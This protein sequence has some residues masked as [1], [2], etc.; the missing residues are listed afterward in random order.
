MRLVHFSS[1]SGNTQRFIDYVGE[2][3][4][5]IPLTSR[6]DP[7]IVTEPYVLVVPTYGGGHVSAAVPKQ[8]IRFLNDH[9]NRALIR[10]VIAIG[11]TNFGTAYCI[12]GDIIAQKCSVP[13]LFRIEIFGTP[14][15]HADVRAGLA[16]FWKGNPA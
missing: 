14:E 2:P 12:A 3:S 10:G 1:T 8:V 16:T 5:R 13:V 4:Q 9:S 7:L 15:D 6:E 11:N